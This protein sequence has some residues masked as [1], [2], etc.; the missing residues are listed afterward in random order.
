MTRLTDQRA[1]LGRRRHAE[2]IEVSGLE[3]GA[4]VVGVGQLDVDLGATVA[5]TAVW[6]ASSR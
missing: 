6:L 3:D 1:R 2:R 5:L 4:I